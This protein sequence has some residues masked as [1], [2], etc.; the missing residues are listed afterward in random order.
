MPEHNEKRADIALPVNLSG[1]SSSM[2]SRIRLKK[3]NREIV[4]PGYLQV[5][6]K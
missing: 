2:A 6:R 4:S 5:E 1:S 3:G